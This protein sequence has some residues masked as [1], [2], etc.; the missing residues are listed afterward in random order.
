MARSLM[1]LLFLSTFFYACGDDEETCEQV[2]VYRLDSERQ[3][4]GDGKQIPELEACMGEPEKGI[5]FECVR[6]P[7]GELYVARRNSAAWLESAS[8]T[9]ENQLDAAEK[10]QCDQ[11]RAVGF[12]SPRQTCPAE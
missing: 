8:W 5:A 10:A 7:E 3:C 6:S 2:S 11:V 9:V 4:Y 12:P 1:S